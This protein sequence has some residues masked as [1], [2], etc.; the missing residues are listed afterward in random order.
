MPVDVSAA[1]PTSGG[2]AVKTSLIRRVVMA[3]SPVGT[4]PPSPFRS[5]ETTMGATAKTTATW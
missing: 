1:M 3:A 5:A 2:W 4:Q